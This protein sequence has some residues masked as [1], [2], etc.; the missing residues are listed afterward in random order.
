MPSSLHVRM[1]YP[2]FAKA[3]PSVQAALRAMTRAVEDAGLEKELTELVKVRVS[4]MNGCA[5]CVQFH[6]TLARKLG[7]PAEKLD[8]VAAWREAGVYTERELAALAWAEIH[9]DMSRHES[10]DAAYADLLKH[11]NATEAVFLTVAIATINTW[12]RIA[13]ALRFV[14]PVPPPASQG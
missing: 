7:V 11:F 3:A 2:D 9:T 10:T 4:Q 14:P 12:N 6:L 8:L 5:F 13:V 1:D